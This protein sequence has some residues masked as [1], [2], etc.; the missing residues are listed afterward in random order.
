MFDKY[1]LIY[2]L[3]LLQVVQKAAIIELKH[4]FDQ[5]DP[6]AYKVMHNPLTLLQSEDIKV[7]F[8]LSF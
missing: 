7:N 5:D 3:K 2:A 4:K 6:I 8:A 1:Y